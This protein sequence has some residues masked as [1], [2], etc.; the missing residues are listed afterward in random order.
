MSSNPSAKQRKLPEISGETNLPWI[1]SNRD[2]P[3]DTLPVHSTTRERYLGANT[4]QTFGNLG[5][6]EGR[7]KR[8]PLFSF[9]SSRPNDLPALDDEL[10]S[11]AKTSQSRP[12]WPSFFDIPEDNAPRDHAAFRASILES[13]PHLL[14]D[15]E[16][17]KFYQGGKQRLN[18]MKRNKTEAKIIKHVQGM[19]FR[20]QQCQVDDMKLR[21]RQTPQVHTHVSEV[22]A[23]FRFTL[24]PYRR[25]TEHSVQYT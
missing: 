18:V 22:F 13:V 10:F 9:L 16:G 2:S 11:E 1:Q 8:K 20:L 14:A 6:A 3:A 5:E 21:Y 12:N 15:S 7:P 25:T 17:R 23:D 4:S 19:A 24:S